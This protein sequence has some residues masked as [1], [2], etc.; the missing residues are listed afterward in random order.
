M[1]FSIHVAMLAYEIGRYSNFNEASV[2]ADMA[3]N[4]NDPAPHYNMGNIEMMRSDDK[5]AAIEFQ[6][7][8]RLEP[9]GN[10]YKTETLFLLGATLFRTGQKT[11]ALAVERQLATYD[12]EFGRKAKNYITRHP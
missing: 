6:Q 1:A 9:A 7:A 8:A 4:P 12:D 3:H 5:A 11:Q 2:Q 10:E